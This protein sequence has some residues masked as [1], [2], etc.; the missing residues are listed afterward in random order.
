M[1]EV[2]G[3]LL[4]PLAN[5]A[6]RY[7]LSRWRQRSPMAVIAIIQSLWEFVFYNWGRIPGLS[8]SPSWFVTHLLTSSIVVQDER[9]K[10][11]VLNWVTA[12]VLV[13]QQTPRSQ[14]LLG[15]VGPSVF[16]G[17]FRKQHEEYT[18]PPGTT[19]HLV[20]LRALA[21]LPAIHRSPSPPT[22]DYGTGIPVHTDHETLK[23]VCFGRSVSLIKEFFAAC[24]AF[25]KDQEESFV[26]VRSSS[27][28]HYSWDQ[29]LL[30]PIRLMDT[31]YL[32]ENIK[33][34]TLS[35]GRNYLGPRTRRFYVSR[36]IPYRRC[37][38][39]YGPPGTGKTSLAIANAGLVALPLYMLRL[40]GVDNDTG[41]ALLFSR[42]DPRCI[43]LLEDIDAVGMKRDLSGAEKHG[44]RTSCT[45]S[46]LLNVL[47]GVA[48]QEGR[49]VIM[50]ANEPESLDEALIRRG[51]I[52]KEVYLGHISADGARQ[53]FMRM[54]TPKTTVE[55]RDDVDEAGIL[56]TKTM[57]SDQT[58]ACTA[59]DGETREKLSR[60]FSSRIP[61]NTLTPAQLQEYLLLYRGDPAGAASNIS[62]WIQDETATMAQK[63]KM[64]GEERKMETPGRHSQGK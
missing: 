6:I 53:M 59:V 42:L 21:L 17:K 14:C 39:F 2:G 9:L 61:A 37:Y 29:K 35:D 19:Q 20:L 38:L 52:D 18:L 54:T 45:L 3:D 26:I 40:P 47:D 50:T 41:L 11:E 56:M 7:I 30:M 43:V 4:G 25:A 28:S 8:S 27:V 10:S 24:R 48:S 51:R 46:G 60:Q 64:T 58:D 57:D 31:I 32:D 23:I 22:T 16:G 15:W 12:K 36:A 44:K 34:E 5:R 63:R 49:I 13:R 62:A 33:S 1:A 55:A